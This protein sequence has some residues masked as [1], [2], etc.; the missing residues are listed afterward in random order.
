MSVNDTS[1]NGSMKFSRGGALFATQLGRGFIEPISPMGKFI[2]GDRIFHEI[3]L[4]RV[5][6]NT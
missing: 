4:A 2:D 5:S 6:S 1:R 3:E